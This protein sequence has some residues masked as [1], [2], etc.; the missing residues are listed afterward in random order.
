MIRQ[1]PA[2]RS[3]EEQTDRALQSPFLR[4]ACVGTVGFVVDASVLT[5]LMGLGWVPVVA[6]LVSFPAAV[7]TTWLLN[8]AWTFG[9]QVHRPVV[10]YLRYSAVQIVGAL[11]NLGIF[12]LLILALPA[13]RAQP[14]APLA[15]AALVALVF[16]YIATRH[17]VFPA[18]RP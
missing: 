3:D 10:G 18:N 4:F 17:W 13:A 5:A 8:K 1:A 14:W 15:V 7:G 11:I 2:N 12:S 16:N 9:A 6:R